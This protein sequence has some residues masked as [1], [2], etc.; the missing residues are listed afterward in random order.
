M[1]KEVYKP[2]PNSKL[3]TLSETIQ[4]FIPDGSSVA[5]GL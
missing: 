3:L 5:M 1:A 4:R 2:L